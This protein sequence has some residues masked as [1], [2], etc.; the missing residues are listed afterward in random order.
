MMEGT[1]VSIMFGA[2]FVARI[3]MMTAFAMRQKCPTAWV[4]NKIT[5]SGEKLGKL[6]SF[7]RSE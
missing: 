1:A 4:I 2:K 7:T 6:Y 5:L 3:T